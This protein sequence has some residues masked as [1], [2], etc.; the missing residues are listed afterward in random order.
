MVLVDVVATDHHGQFLRG[1]KAKDFTVLEDGKPQTVSGF[2][3]H[4]TPATP[5]Q[6]I[7]P[8][9]L[10]PHQFSNFGA[11]PQDPDR[12]VTIVLLDMVNTAGTDQQY[13]RKQMLKF[14]EGLPDG[15]PVAL[16]TLTS[17]LKM[18]QGFTGDSATLVK[19][20]RAVMANIPLTM[21]SEAQ[22]QQEELGAGALE[23]VASPSFMG[24]TGGQ[25]TSDFMPVAPI[26]QAI[27]DALDSEDTFT[28]LVRMDKTLDALETL[29]R[30]VA[31]YPGRKNLLWLSAE[32]PIAFGPNMNPYN[33]AS[34][35]INEGIQPG[36]ITNHQLHNL[37]YETPPLQKTAAL[38]AA[39]QVAVYPI[40]VTG[41]VNLGTGIDISS[42][43]A[44]MSNLGLQQETQAAYQRQTTALWD[45]H[46]AMSDVARQTGGEAFY[47]TNDLKAAM[48]RGMDE[49]SNYYTLAYNPANGKWKGDYRKIEVKADVA[50]AKLTYRRGYYAVE[51]RPYTGDKEAAAMLS[52]MRFSEPEFTMVRMK[53]Q[54]LPPDA[55]HKA[56]RIDFA[57][58]SRDIT[59]VDGSDGRK[60]AAVDFVATAWDKDLKLVTHQAATMNT[61]LRPEAFQQVQKTGLPYHQELEL[62]P[63]TYTLRLGVLDR[64]S[65]RIGTLD[66]PLVVPEPPEATTKPAP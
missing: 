6:A 14:L 59:F 15:R 1:L 40:A 20:A 3:V 10:P 41:V 30:A 34:Q 57:V 65:Q 16:F 24:P 47:G 31:G 5:D 18:V 43:T 63:G 49:G 33:Q 58:N 55:D 48:S 46:E 29:G 12:P 13:A 62:K 60:L 17:H 35:P 36:A 38:L 51:T 11:V 26:G 64:G 44:Y 50:G 66:V 2:V 25:G 7:P 21:S 52:A 53:A 28:K 23:S 56:V 54:V 22:Q 39:A 27:R 61:T 45:T 8:V 42:Q 32:F 4:E 37:E 9:K 19:A